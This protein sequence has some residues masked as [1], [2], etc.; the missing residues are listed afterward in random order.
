M[1]V[2]PLAIEGIDAHV[3]GSD[4]IAFAV[5]QGKG[6]SARAQVCVTTAW[7]PMRIQ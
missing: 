3:G 7:T 4:N 6:R 1:I 2:R 5:W